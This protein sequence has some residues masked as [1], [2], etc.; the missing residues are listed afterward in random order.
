MVGADLLAAQFASFQA[1]ANIQEKIG[2]IQEK[3][4]FLNKADDVK[5]FFNDVW[6][7]NEEKTFKSF[8]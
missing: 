7:N 2:D 3:T 6:W 1:Y 5:Y 4:N 8:F